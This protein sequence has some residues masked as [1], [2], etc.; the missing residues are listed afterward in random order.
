MWISGGEDRCAERQQNH[1]QK[2]SLATTAGQK[3]AKL[4][5]QRSQTSLR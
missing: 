2:R 4:V 3:E 5:S 1:H